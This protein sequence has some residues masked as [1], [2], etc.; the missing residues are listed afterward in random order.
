M[1]FVLTD[2]PIHYV[3]GI[4]Q[5]KN[6]YKITKSDLKSTISLCVSNK[7]STLNRKMFVEFILHTITTFCSCSFSY[8]ETIIQLF[9]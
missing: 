6:R 3:R 8:L 4:D 5:Q 9:R 2:N 7:R 1:T